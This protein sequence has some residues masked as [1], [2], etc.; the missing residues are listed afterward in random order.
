MRIIIIAR[1]MLGTVATLFTLTGVCMVL[2]NE[3]ENAE[4][5]AKKR[6]AE[7]KQLGI[8][9]ADASDYLTNEVRYYVQFGERVHYD[10]Y[11]REVR[12]TRTRDRVVQR[13]TELGA[14]RAEIELIELA[15]RNSDALIAIEEAAMAAVGEGE[16][17]TARHLVFDQKYVEHKKS[18]MRPISSFQKV[19]NSRAAREAEAAL[20]RAEL[21]LVLSNILTL[22]SACSTMALIY[23]VLIR[24][25]VQPVT[26]L[27]DSMLKLAGRRYEC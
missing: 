27:T 25:T 19:M 23:F 9:L 26:A 21:M 24:R 2:L 7:F 11:W 15:K 22:L 10:N 17:D 3:S 18:I 16:Y 12:E 20:A 13:L 4:S 6:Q 8:D 1:I 14:R 5:L